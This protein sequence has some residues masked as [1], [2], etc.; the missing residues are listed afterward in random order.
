MQTAKW[1]KT[2]MLDGITPALIAKHINRVMPEGEPPVSQKE[3]FNAMAYDLI[4]E[5]IKGMILF[6]R[7]E[8]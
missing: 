7:H 6:R 4:I 8:D 2:E 3:M 1:P 5:E